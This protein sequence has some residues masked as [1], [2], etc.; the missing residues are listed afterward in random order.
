MWGLVGR[1]PIE[2]AEKTYQ[3]LYCIHC[4][5]ISSGGCAPK[6]S[7][8]G[9]LRSSINAT[10]FLPPGGAK[11]SFVRFSIRASKLE[12]TRVDEVRAEKLTS[13]VTYDSSRRARAA[14]TSE[15][16]PTP[17]SPV[18]SVLVPARIRLARR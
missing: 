11:V 1:D 13:V 8:S 4:R 15:V 3:K 17:T 7:F 14:L 16:L 10:S 5:R 18:T 9:M 12:E 2:S 6:I